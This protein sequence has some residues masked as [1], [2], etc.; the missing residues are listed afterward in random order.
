MTAPCEY[1]LYLA[2]NSIEEIFM[3]WRN[4]MPK[5]Q[6]LDLRNN[7]FKYLTHQDLMY[8]SV[9]I[10]KRG[11]ANP[12]DCTQKLIVDLR[13]NLIRGIEVPSSMIMKNEPR[14]L[15]AD[16]YGHATILLDNNP[17]SCDCEMLQFLRLF[18]GDI[19][20]TSELFRTEGKNWVLPAKIDIGNL[21]C[22]EPESVLGK[23]LTDPEE[24]MYH[25][26]PLSG[27]CAA[28]P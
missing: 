2:N 8:S 16:V 9:F 18:N 6:K 25:L 21:S 22:S 27:I 17:F 1:E 14:Y 24:W 15:G 19:V 12:F 26:L 20:L 11:R 28:L 5:L 7:K 10:D 3:D 13:Y 23:K 4:V